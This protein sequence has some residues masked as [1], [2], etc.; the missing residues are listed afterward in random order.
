[1]IVRFHTVRLFFHNVALFFVITFNGIGW[2]V[3]LI[4]AMFLHIVW[5]FISKWIRTLSSFTILRLTVYFPLAINCSQVIF[6]SNFISTVQ[7]PLEL[8]SVFSQILLTG[9]DYY[10]LLKA[11]TI[12]N[13]FR[14]SCMTYHAVFLLNH[15]EMSYL[16]RSLI[17]LKVARLLETGFELCLYHCIKVE[18]SIALLKA[19]SLFQC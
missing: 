5:A 4:A 16:I 17:T 9:L 13:C 15:C 2:I 7:L 10:V 14:Q 3:I 18:N 12:S 6:H 11:L 1:M 8:I 19:L